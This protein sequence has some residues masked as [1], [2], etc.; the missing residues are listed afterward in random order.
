MA[1]LYLPK[2]T[3]TGV[4]EAIQISRSDEANRSSTRPVTGAPVLNSNN[5]TADVVPSFSFPSA[6]PG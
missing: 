4:F 5:F 3:E 1:G 6:A 2:P